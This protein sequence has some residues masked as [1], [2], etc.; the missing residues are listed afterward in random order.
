M[1]RWLRGTARGQSLVETAMILPIMLVLTFGVM[2][3]G[4]AFYAYVQVINSAREGARAASQYRYLYQSPY[5]GNTY[6]VA[7]NDGNR[8]FGDPSGSMRYEDRNEDNAEAVARQS[9]GTLNPGSLTVVVE[10][11]DALDSTNNPSRS[12]QPVTVRV[13]YPYELPVTS[14]FGFLQPTVTLR[15]VSTAMIAQQ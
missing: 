15:A 1:W 13:S 5:T 8:G 2:D 4:F 9:V 12:R 10:Y 7:Q 11:A 14:R 6:T 3:A